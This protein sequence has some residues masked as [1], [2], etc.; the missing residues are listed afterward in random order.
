[1]ESL[2]EDIELFK[3]RVVCTKDDAM[4]LVR[5]PQFNIDQDLNI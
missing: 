5:W 4:A 1:M 2:V 3:H